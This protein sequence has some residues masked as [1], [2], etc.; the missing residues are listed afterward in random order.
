MRCRAFFFALFAVV[1]LV[2]G[3]KN[4]LQQVGGTAPAKRYLT[5]VSLS[6]S[7]TELV[8]TKATG[9]A[10]LGRTAQCNWPT[11]NSKVPVV[12]KGVKPN[13]EQI[14]QL[15]PSIVIYDDLLFPDTADIAKFKELGIET[16][17][18]KGNTIEDFVKCVFLFGKTFRAESSC[19]EYVDNIQAAVKAAIGSPPAKKLKVAI[20][21]PGGG[22]EHYIVGTDSF[23]ADVVRK[24]QGEIVGPR[25]DKFVPL[26]A[27]SLVSMNPDVIISAGVGTTIEKDP[28]LQSI[29]AI[30]AKRVVPVDPDILLRRGARVNMLIRGIYNILSEAAQP[31]PGR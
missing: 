29:S 18:V 2:A 7:A 26:S 10:L 25:G 20:L 12:M 13:Y 1:L 19:S 9:V 31:E 17:A 8:T 3:C 4:S 21:M 30:G 6:P 27:E 28:R 16:F 11:I 23:L 15:K 5:V 24:S 22:S 14:V